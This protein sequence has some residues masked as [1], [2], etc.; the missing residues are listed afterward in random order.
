MEQTG[1]IQRFKRDILGRRIGDEKC[2]SIMS[3]RVWLRC[4]MC[5]RPVGT[6]ASVGGGVLGGCPPFALRLATPLVGC[7]ANLLD[8]R[9]TRVGR[10]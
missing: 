6:L 10:D 4:Q 3:Q 5:T 9:S 2:I 8:G 7:V 1:I